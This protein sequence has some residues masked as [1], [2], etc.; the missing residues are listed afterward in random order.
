MINLARR[1]GFKI[2]IQLEDGVVNMVLPCAERVE[3]RNVQ[4]MEGMKNFRH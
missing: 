3:G 1:L 2:D 4:K